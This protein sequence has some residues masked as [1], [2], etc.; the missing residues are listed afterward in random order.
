MLFCFELFYMLMRNYL[1]VLL[2]KSYFPAASLYSLLPSLSFHP[3]CFIS[4]SS[5]LIFSLPVL[6]LLSTLFS[7]WLAVS[8]FTFVFPQL[9]ACRCWGSTLFAGGK[10]REGSSGGHNRCFLPC[11]EHPTSVT[12]RQAGRRVSVTL[13]T[14]RTGEIH[15]A[16]RADCGRW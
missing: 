10:S 8:T 3:K 7:I 13:T 12:R 2:A 4:H 5:H 6:V 15:E 9:T 16:E 11:R 14:F 1:A